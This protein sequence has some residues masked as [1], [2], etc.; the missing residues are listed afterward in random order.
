M[1]RAQIER[2]IAHDQQAPSSDRIDHLL[3][4]PITRR[5]LQRFGADEKAET[6]EALYETL[7]QL[8]DEDSQKVWRALEDID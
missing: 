6:L 8:S 1:Y 5:V 4:Q 2:W 7:K 3:E